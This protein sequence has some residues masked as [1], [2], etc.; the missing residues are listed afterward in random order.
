MTVQL[1]LEEIQKFRAILEKIESRQVGLQESY[2]LIEELTVLKQ[3]IDTEINTLETKLIS[4]SA[5]SKNNLNQ[6]T[7][8]F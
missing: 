8:D 3:E 6:A 5:D 1:T 7:N 4:L 2:T